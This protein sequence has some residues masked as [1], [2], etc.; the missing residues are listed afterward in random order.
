MTILFP[1]PNLTFPSKTLSVQNAQIRV[2]NDG[3]TFSG[4]LSISIFDSACQQ[5]VGDGSY[6]LKVIKFFIMLS[7]IM[8]IF[9]MK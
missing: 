5:P 8:L 4:P 9:L 7:F 3:N 1:L 2:S 6:K